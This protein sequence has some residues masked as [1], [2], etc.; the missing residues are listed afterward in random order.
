MRNFDSANAVKQSVCCER[1]TNMTGETSKF[2]EQQAEL[3]RIWNLTIASLSKTIRPVVL[4]QSF[5]AKLEACHW[6]VTGHLGLSVSLSPDI[7]SGPDRVILILDELDQTILNNPSNAQWKRLQSLIASD[8]PLL[9]VTQGSQ[10]TS[11]TNPDNAL[12]HGLFRVVRRETYG[13][14]LTTLDVGGYGEDGDNSSLSSETE[15][16]IWH[17]ITAIRAGRAEGEYVERNS[18][19]HI[20]RIVPDVEMNQ[21]KRPRLVERGLWEGENRVQLCADR[22]GSLELTWH[23]K[24]PEKKDLEEGCIQV[25]VKAV[26]VNFKVSYTKQSVKRKAWRPGNPSATNLRLLFNHLIRILPQQWALSQKTNTC[27]DASVPAS[28]ATWGLG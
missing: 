24:Q 4:S 13:A 11:V 14:R 5:R 3:P 23:E 10:Y 26:G 6:T 16:A 12:V 7:L 20:Q 28:Y 22:V 15:D 8:L 19:L 2:R 17:V 18:L 1:A 25:E 27:S 9:W 21:L